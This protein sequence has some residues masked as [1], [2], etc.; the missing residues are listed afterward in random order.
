[1]AAFKKL[2]FFFYYS[3]CFTTSKEEMTTTHT[4]HE[5]S[6]QRNQKFAEFIRSEE[7]QQQLKNMNKSK[8]LAWLRDAFK[9]KYNVSIPPS[10]AY[11]AIQ[12]VDDRFKPK[13]RQQTAKPQLVAVTNK[14]SDQI[15]SESIDEIINENPEVNELI[16]Q[17]QRIRESTN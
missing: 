9:D 7:V 4:T 3:D 16:D 13:P 15:I 8:C 17:I 2:S 1:M 11:K 10:A 14:S 6:R 12:T 5:Q